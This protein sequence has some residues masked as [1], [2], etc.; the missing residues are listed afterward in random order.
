MRRLTNSFIIVLAVG[1]W[2]A[3]ASAK[4]GRPWPGLPNF[5]ITSRFVEPPQRN[6]D[7]CLVIG[8]PPSEEY[9]LAA[10]GVVKVTLPI[11]ISMTSGSLT[12]EVH[13]SMAWPERKQNNQE[14]RVR[15]ER[16]GE[17]VVKI[18]M[19]VAAGDHRVDEIDLEMPISVG[20]KDVTYSNG[21]ATR[22]ETIRD[23]QRYRYAGRTLVP[24]QSSESIVMTDLEGQG[25]KILHEETGT[26]RECNLESD[27]KVPF[28]VIVDQAGKIVRA[29]YTLD[30]QGTEKSKSGTESS[31]T[32][33]A[34]VALERWRFE[35]ARAKGIPVAHYIEVDVTVRSDNQ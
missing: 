32:R 27:V 7:A 10:V 20:E 33:A 8:V 21:Y 22:I 30:Y 5:G 12:F 16:N 29:D 34:L 26:C 28:I 9:D 11:G 25:V 15:F 35:P 2:T 18:S 23:G 4:P 1:T 3:A 13:P 14:I 19:Q 17:F 31:V 24:I 6:A